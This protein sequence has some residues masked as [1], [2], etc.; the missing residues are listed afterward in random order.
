VFIVPQ[1]AQTDAAIKVQEE[2]F[3]YI[4]FIGVRVNCPSSVE[5]DVVQEI[6]ECAA[7]KRDVFYFESELFLVT[8][9]ESIIESYNVFS[10]ELHGAGRLV[11]EYLGPEFFDVMEPGCD[12]SGADAPIQVLHDLWVRVLCNFNNGGF[13][14]PLPGHSHTFFNFRFVGA[15]NSEGVGRRVAEQETPN[16][17]TD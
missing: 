8:I 13:V 4:E 15:K 9:K 7:E 2:I 12:F 16:M 5:L 3:L 6:K 1:V 11:L 14:V 10:K 17:E